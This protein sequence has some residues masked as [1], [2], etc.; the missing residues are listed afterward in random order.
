VA[1]GEVGMGGSASASAA[2]PTAGRCPTGLLYG[3]VQSG[4][5]AAMIVSTA[6]AVD[7]GFRIVIVFTSNYVKL[8]EQTEKNRT[9]YAKVR[10]TMNPHE[11]ISVVEREV[12]RSSEKELLNLGQNR[13]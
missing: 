3:R 12:G 7:N 8:V 2:A 5:T 10:A 9:V 11:V 13:P 4:K 6:L 1:A